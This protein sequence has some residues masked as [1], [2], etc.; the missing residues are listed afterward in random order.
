M[1]LQEVGWYSK[2]G[3]VKHPVIDAPS[4][5]AM[6]GGPSVVQGIESGLAVCKTSSWQADKQA[7]PFSLAVGWWVGVCACVPL[8]MIDNLKYVFRKLRRECY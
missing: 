8:S 6:L 4:L 5:V 7:V 1:E 2:R 3:V